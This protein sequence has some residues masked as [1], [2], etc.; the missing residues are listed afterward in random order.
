MRLR[1]KPSETELE[2]SLALFKDLPDSEIEKLSARALRHLESAPIDSSGTE[3]N[4]ADATLGKPRRHQDWFVAAGI[5][6]LVIIAIFLPTRLVRS[7]PAVLEESTGLRKVQYGEVVRGGTLKFPDGSRVH[8]RPESTVVL[9]RVDDGARLSLQ[10]GQMVVLS[11]AARVQQ[12]ATDRTL[13]AGEK[14]ETDPFKALLAFEV[15]SI[16]PSTAASIPGA[17]GGAGG[18]TVLPQGCAMVGSQVDPKRFAVGN[19]TLYTL[20]AWAYGSNFINPMEGGCVDLVKLGRISGGPSWAKSDQW[21]IQAVMPTE[22]PYSNQELRRGAAPELKRMILTML[23]ERFHLVIRRETK[24]MPAYALVAET[25][26]PV[27]KVPDQYPGGADGFKTFWERQP[28]GRVVKEIYAW[29]GK[30]VSMADLVAALPGE[31]ERP[32]IDRTGLKGPFN[33][34]VLFSAVNGLSFGKPGPSIFDALKK[35]VG[36]RLDNDKTNVESWVIESAD[37]PTEN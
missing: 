37:K 19:V 32:V 18:I 7:A 6:A 11:G 2:E 15:V 3:A 16:R 21:D 31:V 24:E 20:V 29:W 8:I 14:A 35:Q 25:E 17:R 34:Y 26:T 27:L 30:D 28:S 12:G 4:A 23:E 13:R 9:E 36:L 1:A 33:F 22:L 10:Q 5:A